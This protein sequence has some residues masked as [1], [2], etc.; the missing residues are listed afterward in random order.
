[1]SRC[2]VNVTTFD[3]KLEVTIPLP[4][5][6]RSEKHN[7]AECLFGDTEVEDINTS[8][9]TPRRLLYVFILF[10][11]Y[12]SLGSLESAKHVK[13]ARVLTPLSKTAVLGSVL[14]ATDSGLCF[15]VNREQSNREYSGE[16]SRSIDFLVSFWLRGR[17]YV[18]D[19]YSTDSR[20]NGVFRNWLEPK[21]G[22][23]ETQTDLEIYN[24]IQA[25]WHKY[26][27]TNSVIGCIEAGTWWNIQYVEPFKSTQI[28][29]SAL[30]VRIVMSH[31]KRVDSVNKR[32]S[33]RTEDMPSKRR[34][35]SSPD[36][37]LA[38]H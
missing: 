24:K 20:S 31:A 38:S 25:K 23:F 11:A 22:N 1:M 17:R 36:P 10:C 33:S 2:A 9:T 5:S 28:E 8:T 26:R 16:L 7:L 4:R 6:G 29:F 15:I 32:R 37:T 12:V 13:G 35:K 19:S 18:I 21:R 3:G 30:R 14:E 34:R 27:G